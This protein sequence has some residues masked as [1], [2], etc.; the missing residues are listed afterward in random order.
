MNT[1]ERNLKEYFIKEPKTG[2][3]MV[4]EQRPAGDFSEMDESQFRNY[5]ENIFIRFI[6]SIN[7]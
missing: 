4:I 6:A 2:I 5:V 1:F 3:E 7:D